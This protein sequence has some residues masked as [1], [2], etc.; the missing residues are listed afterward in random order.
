MTRRTRPLLAT[1]L[2]AAVP[3][4]VTGCASSSSAAPAPGVAVSAPAAATGQAPSVV[5][6]AVVVAGGKV[7]P[8]PANVPVPVGSPVRLAVTSDVADEIHVHGYDLEKTVQ[9]GS[10]AT[11]DFTATQTG[12]FEVETHESGL[13][14]LKLVVS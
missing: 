5:L 13:L 1:T 3:L 7:T 6:L 8:A 9:P 4:V 12:T 10:T 14:L 11:F 2:L